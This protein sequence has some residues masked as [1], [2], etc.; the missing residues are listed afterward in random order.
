MK[1]SAN[2]Y[3]CW[4]RRPPPRPVLRFSMQIWR[5]SRCL[6]L[7]VFP[8]LL[9]W[10][11]DVVVLWRSSLALMCIYYVHVFHIIHLS[12]PENTIII[13]VAT[14]MNTCIIIIII[15]IIII[16]IFHFLGLCEGVRRNSAIDLLDNT[17]AFFALKCGYQT[18]LNDTWEHNQLHWKL[19]N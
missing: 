2:W 4:E 5:L 14:N 18:V 19:N 8:E 6:C 1:T 9:K 12:K 3:S 17:Q 13:H 7:D 11:Q 10:C 15:I 16:P